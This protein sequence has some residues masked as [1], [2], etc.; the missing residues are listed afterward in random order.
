M[1][2]YSVHADFIAAIK[3]Y[4]IFVDLRSLLREKVNGVYALKVVVEDPR[5]MNKFVY[6]LG[7]L[8]VSFAEG[9]D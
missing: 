5:A 4:Q 3:R 6:G 1:I 9:S 8:T 2:S 7:N